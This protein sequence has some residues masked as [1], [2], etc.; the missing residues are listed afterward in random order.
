MR[1]DAARAE[2][3]RELLG[4]GLRGHLAADEAEEAF[5]ASGAKRLLLTHRPKERPLDPAFEQVH[6]GYETEI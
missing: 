5:E 2:S 6:D 1:G 3:V 4:F